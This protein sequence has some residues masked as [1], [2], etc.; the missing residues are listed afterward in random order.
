[1][2]ERCQQCGQLKSTQLAHYQQGKRIGYQRGLF[3]AWKA[4]NKAMLYYPP[5]MDFPQA[6]FARQLVNHLA[7]TVRKLEKSS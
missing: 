3:A 2:L 5:A 4:I 6:N 1:M 7:E